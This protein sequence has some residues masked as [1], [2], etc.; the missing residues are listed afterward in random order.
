MDTHLPSIIHLLY[1][2]QPYIAPFQVSSSTANWSGH[3]KV[4]N[5]T[6]RFK[7]SS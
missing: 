3:T 1:L 2:V 5:L 4:L 6:A 7:T